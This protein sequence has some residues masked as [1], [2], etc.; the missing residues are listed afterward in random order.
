MRRTWT[1][2]VDEGI[3]ILSAEPLTITNFLSSLNVSY[4]IIKR[5]IQ[6]IEDRGILETFEKKG[7]SNKLCTHYKVKLP[8][9]RLRQ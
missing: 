3:E 8:L 6:E 7:R 1:Q 5:V 2:I 9:N 4:P